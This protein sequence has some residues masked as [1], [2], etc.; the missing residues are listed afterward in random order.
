[1][2]CNQFKPGDK[3]VCIDIPEG[4][5]RLKLGKVYTVRKIDMYNNSLSE[6]VYLEKDTIGGWYPGRFRLLHSNYWKIHK[7]MFRLRVGKQ[8]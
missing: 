6:F 7:R 2:G 4:S 1:M 5:T 3:V 8:K